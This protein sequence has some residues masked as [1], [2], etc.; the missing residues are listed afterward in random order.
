MDKSLE[1]QLTANTKNTAS[2]SSHNEPSNKGENLTLKFPDQD[3]KTTEFRAELLVEPKTHTIKIESDT[4]WPTVIATTL[5]GAA[6]IL[7]TILVGWFAHTVQKN[8]IRSNTANFRHAWQI[9]LRERM[10]DFLAKIAFMH[11]KKERTPNYFN[12][13]DSDAEYSDLIKIQASIMLMLDPQKD[14]SKE[15]NDLMNEC[16]KALKDGT[17][18]KLNQKA[19]ELTVKANELLELAWTDIKNDLGVR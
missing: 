8:Q 3:N 2:N 9:Q 11:Y 6:G 13:T 18:E 12:T 5:V 19:N 15:T 10:S 1:T 17:I 14:Y 4:D 16:I 7:T